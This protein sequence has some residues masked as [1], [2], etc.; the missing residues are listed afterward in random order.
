MIA[1][2]TVY[3]STMDWNSRKDDIA[4]RFSEMIGKKI[5]FTNNISVSLFPHPHLSVDGINILSP[6]GSETIA[7]IGRMETGISLRSLLSGTPDINS[8]ELYE[9]ELWYTVGKEGNSNWSWN[10]GSQLMDDGE[11]SAYLRNFNI[12]NS[13]IH[14]MNKKYDISFDLEQFNADIQAESLTGPYRIDGNFMKGNNHFG[15]ALSVN[16]LTQMEDVPVSF[17]L[18]DPNSEGYLRYDGTYNTENRYI[19]GDF[20]GGSAKTADFINNVLGKSVL[21]EEYNIPAQ[22]SVNAQTEYG[23]LHLKSLVVKLGQLIEGSGSVEVN[24]SEQQDQ[25]SKV[26]IRYQMVE[27]DIRPLMLFFKHEFELYKSEQKTFEPD[28]KYDVSFDLSSEKLVISGEPTGFL[29]NV[30]A[31]G[32][33]KN[34]DFT[35]NEFYAACPGNIVLNMSGS[36]VEEDSQPHYF[37]KVAADGQNLLSLINALGI[38]LDSPVQSSYHDVQIEFD[39]AGNNKKAEVSNVKLAMDK[40]K[41]EGKMQVDFDRKNRYIIELSAD[42]INFDNYLET[43]ESKDDLIEAVKDDF[44]RL[45]FLKDIPVH[46]DFSASDVIFRSIAFEKVSIVAD[47]E[48]DVLK[49]D[50]IDI[51]NVLDTKVQADLSLSGL[52]S[53]GFVINYANYDLMTKNAKQVI[54]K[55][56]LNFPKWKIFENSELKVLGSLK[57][58]LKNFDINFQ[59]MGDDLYFSYNGQLLQKENLE[60]V[61]QIELKTTHIG[62]LIQSLNGKEI[63]ISNSALNCSGNLSGTRYDWNFEKAK[64]LLGTSEYRGTLSVKSDKN[65]QIKSDVEITD[66]DLSNVIKLQEGGTEIKSDSLYTDNFIARPNFSRNIINFDV[67]RNVDMDINLKAQKFSYKNI[68]GEQLQT[69]LTNAQNVMQIKDLKFK[70]KDADFKGDIQI[71]YIQNPRI[72]GILNVDH[73]NIIDL[74]GKIYKLSLKNLKMESNFESAAS[75]LNDFA[76]GISGEIKFSADNALINGMDFSNINEDI[77]GR[78]YSEGTFQV[79]RDNL[80]QGVSEFDF[81]NGQIS[82]SNGILELRDTVMKNPLVQLLFSGKISLSEWKMNI[83]VQTQMLQLNEIPYF[84]FSLNGMINKPTLDVNVEKLVQKYDEHWEQV[85]LQ[86]QQ[87]KEREQKALE[88]RMSDVQIKV[89]D[90]STELNKYLATLETYHSSSDIDESKLWYQK[91]IDTF[92]EINKVIDSMQ[93]VARQNGYTE[94]DVVSIEKDCNA[95]NLKLKQLIAEINQYYVRDL[96]QKIIRTQDLAD[97]LEAKRIE[98]YNDYQKML[99]DDFEILMKIDASQYMINNTDMKMKQTRLANLNENLHDLYKNFKKEYQSKNRY[100]KIQDQEVALSEL[101]FSLQKMQEQYS[102]L[103]NVRNDISDMLLK[104]VNERQ[105]E[106]DMKNALAQGPETKSVNEDLLKKQSQEVSEIYQNATESETDEKQVESDGNDQKK[107]EM[108]TDSREETPVKEEDNHKVL[109]GVSGKIVTSYDVKDRTIQGTEKTSN[110]LKPITN[111]VPVLSGTIKV[112]E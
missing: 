9:A 13:I 61:G 76:S 26:D 90:L 29:E 92:A 7:K 55:L 103:E 2:L 10:R 27:A 108:N 36:I 31:K 104:L 34:N 80:Q 16:D 64:C 56:G 11:E 20:T 3:V 8:V 83:D 1:G 54:A 41:T 50:K 30:S 32:E 46:I 39:L 66:F 24:F 78:K 68:K 53:D 87:R 110:I 86:E 37:L 23:A 82:M 14:Y 63:S 52:G 33:W 47:N 106:Y 107:T 62:R 5:E 79:V 72:K 70:H 93:S 15:I 105:K 71:D 67:Y 12:Q 99:Q 45:G 6:N 111:D 18:T 35:L 4:A 17:A 102:L 109:N 40:M 21:S 95:Y 38:K 65:Y 57:G 101:K 81:L 98:L 42:K 58:D 75:S 49:L 44:Q 77:R 88:K 74:G 94:K 91:K 28:S 25:R 97:N 48:G 84:E 100:A 96:H 89:T 43:V 112:K 60:F 19:H 59:T 85:S 51:G 22:F 69:H 73:F